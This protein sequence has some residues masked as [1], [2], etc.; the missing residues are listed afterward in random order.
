MNT[1]IYFGIGLLGVVAFCLIKANSLQQDATVANIPF[2]P[3]T[4]FKRD[5]LGISL[6]VVAVF[7]W[8]AIFQET[9]DKYPQIQGYIRTSF[10]GVG[11]MGSYILQLIFGRAKSAIRNIVDEKTNE[12]DRIKTG[13]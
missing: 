5:W 3:Q 10:A 7:I 12:L 1:L 4:Y 2:N 9:A 13:N 11:F 6:S 8:A